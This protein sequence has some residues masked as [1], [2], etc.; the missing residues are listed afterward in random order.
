MAWPYENCCLGSLNLSQ[1]FGESHTVQWDHLAK[2]VALATR[3]LDD[4][5]TANAYVPAA[6]NFGMQH[7]EHAELDWESW[8]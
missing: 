7:S 5:V 1:H 3:F 4:V 2:D 6:P 8:A